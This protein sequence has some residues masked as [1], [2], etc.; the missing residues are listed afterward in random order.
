MIC[1]DCLAT[2]TSSGY[3]VMCGKYNKPAHH[4]G[5]ANKKGMGQPGDSPRAIRDKVNG[6][7]KD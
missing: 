2:V 5:T 6:F 4:Y 1:A 7:R 3:C